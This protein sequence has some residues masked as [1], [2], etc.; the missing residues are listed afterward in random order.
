MRQK[1]SEFLGRILTSVLPISN[2]EYS[3]YVKNSHLK[4]NLLA[5]R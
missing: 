1:K 4:K 5:D 2:S 3:V